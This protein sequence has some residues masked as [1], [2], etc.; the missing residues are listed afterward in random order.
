MHDVVDLRSDTLTLPTPAMREAM[1]RAEVGD[2]V[3]EEDPD[4]PAARGHRGPAHRARRR[5]CSSPRARRATSSRC[6][7]RRAPGRKWCS[8]PTR[9]IF[10]Y[11]GGG[12]ARLRRRADPAGQDRARLPHARAGARAH[13]ARTTSTCPMTGLV[14][15]ENTHNRHGGT[16][17]TPEE[18]DGGGRGGP[19]GRR[20]GAPR[21][22]PALQR[23][24]GA[25]AAGG[26]LRAPGG[27][28][29]LLPVQGP[30]RA[31]GLAGVRLARAS[32]RG[33][34]ACARCS[35]AACGRWACSPRPASSRSTP[36]WTGSPRI[37]PTRAASPRA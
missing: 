30:R 35:A 37:T 26:R 32:S 1:A 16:C 18:I 22:R 34:G 15:V 20:T 21:R 2:D 8:T 23:R 13:P 5:R 31:G 11:E 14:C 33:P 7:P 19:R 4:R 3:W 17:C 12:A 28:G 24:G 27:L 10:N 6:S 29:H 9:H 36:W 25:R